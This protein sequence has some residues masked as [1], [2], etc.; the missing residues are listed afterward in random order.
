MA[1]WREVRVSRSMRVGFWPGKFLR[2]YAVA[3]ESL[4]QKNKGFSTSQMATEYKLPE[5]NC[6]ILQQA[7]TLAYLLEASDRKVSASHYAST[8]CNFGCLASL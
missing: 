4:R 6:D 7:S 5:L 3:T 8:F 2:V 1:T